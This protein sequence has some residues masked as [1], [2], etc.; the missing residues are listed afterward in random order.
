MLDRTSSEVTEKRASDLPTFVDF[1]IVS[2]GT[3]RWLLPA[4]SAGKQASSNM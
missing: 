2:M 3:S 4:S 1:E